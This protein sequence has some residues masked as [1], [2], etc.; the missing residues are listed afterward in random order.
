MHAG[1]TDRAN[2]LQRL[3]VL[4]KAGLDHLG[5]IG[6]RCTHALPHFSLEKDLCI[7][8]A[9]RWTAVATEPRALSQMLNALPI[10]R[11]DSSVSAASFSAISPAAASS[12]WARWPRVWP[13]F[14]R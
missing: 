3:V 5:D 13:L 6:K 12:H 1:H 7:S 2:A 11:M 10:V 8:V 9:A 4:A 14:W